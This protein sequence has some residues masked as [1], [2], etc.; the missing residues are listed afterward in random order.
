MIKIVE[1]A[2]NN[3]EMSHRATS[4]D[5][6]HSAFVNLTVFFWLHKGCTGVCQFIQTSAKEKVSGGN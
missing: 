2:F 5:A 4:D 3:E 6:P 1:L